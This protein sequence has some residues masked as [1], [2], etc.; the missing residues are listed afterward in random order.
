MRFLF[1]I[2]IPEPSVSKAVSKI[3]QFK[4]FLKQNDKRRRGKVLTSQ[5]GITFES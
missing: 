5:S 3:E 2:I 1:F 4:R